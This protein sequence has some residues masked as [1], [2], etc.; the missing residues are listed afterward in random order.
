MSTRW[1]LTIDCAHPK[2]LAAFWASALGYVEKPPPA[3]FAGWE[4][5]YAHHGVPEE[6]WDDGAAL[7]DPDGAGPDLSFLKVPEPKTVKNRLHLDVQAGGGRA[8]PWET[9]WPRV[10]EAVL[11]LTA[12]GA[13]VIQEY[14]LDGRPDHVM[15]ADPEGHEF[16]VL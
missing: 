8:T 15:M 16:C 3:G 7:T 9:R 14:E 12:A 2:A 4:E 11:R 10:T 6:E 13:T 5:W 1:S